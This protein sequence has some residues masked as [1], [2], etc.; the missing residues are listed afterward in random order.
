ME[1][2]AGMN[3]APEPEREVQI[4]YNRHA[5]TLLLELAPPRQATRVTRRGSVIVHT[6]DSGQPVILEIE[7]ASDFLLAI[8]RTS[9]REY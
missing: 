2:V 7:A 4:F 1:S 3:Q 8:I 6:S 9:I 5:D